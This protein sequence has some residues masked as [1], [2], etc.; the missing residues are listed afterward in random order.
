M[1]IKL[2]SMSRMSND[3]LI[4][5]GFKPIPNFT[6]QNSVTYD[7]GR[8]RFL[9]AGSV[10]TPNE[11]IFI[12]EINPKDNNK[13]TDSICLHNY[14]YDGYLTEKRVLSLIGVL[15]NDDNE[16]FIKNNDG[17]RFKENIS[18]SQQNQSQPTLVDI[19]TIEQLDNDCSKLI[20]EMREKNKNKSYKDL[21][22]DYLTEIQLNKRIQFKIPFCEWLDNKFN[23]WQQSK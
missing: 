1:N 5:L 12:Y 8:N 23:K 17:I 21:Y 13:V 22:N 20:E 3:D 15:K 19:S 6:V 7:L 4:K 11:M 10:G 2:K 18:Q 16:Y 14:D 9:S